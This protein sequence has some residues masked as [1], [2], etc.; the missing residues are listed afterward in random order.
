[1]IKHICPNCKGIAYSIVSAMW[2]SPCDKRME[3]EKLPADIG[4][5]VFYPSRPNATTVDHWEWKKGKGLSV[6][7]KHGGTCKSEWTLKEL[8]NA[9]FPKG[10]GLPVVTEKRGDE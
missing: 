8:L 3:Q 9:D 6:F 1:M 10:D 2:C 4:K 7:Y 5:I